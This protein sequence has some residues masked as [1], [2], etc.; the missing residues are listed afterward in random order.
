MITEEQI[1]SALKE[2]IFKGE[3]ASASPRTLTLRRAEKIYDLLF[4]EMKLSQHGATASCAL[5]I[6]SALNSIEEQL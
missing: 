4:D 3:I 2:V 6:L 5:V 1:R